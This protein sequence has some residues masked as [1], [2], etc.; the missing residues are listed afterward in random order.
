MTD[1]AI[2]IVLFAASTIVVPTLNKLLHAEQ[3]AGVVITGRIDAD[4]AQLEQQLNLANIPNIRYQAGNPLHTVQ[5]VET[6]RGNSG[7]IFTFS[8]KLP[9]IIIKAFSNGLYN[10]HASNLPKYRGAMPL[11]WQI[12]NQESQGCLTIIKAEQEFD[13]GDI[14]LQQSIPLHALDTLYSFGHVMAEH[15]VDFVQMFIGKL[16]DKTLIAKPQQ[17]EVC[18]APMPEQ[19]DL[20]VNWQTMNGESISAMARAGNPLFNGAMIM[21]QQ[22]FVGLLQA[23][24]VNHPAY[25]VPAGTILHLGEPEGLLVATLDGA[26]RLDVLTVSEGTFSGLTFAERFGLD[27]GMQ[28]DDIA[29]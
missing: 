3:L 6:W 5:Q 13:T 28:F 20:I 17:G 15:S 16:Q 24:R 9:L 19:Q 1:E 8:H 7:L 21:W 11:Y 25:G 22:S 23:T 26:L 2:K 10:L 14:M 18:G 12:R 27:A 29:G 4:S